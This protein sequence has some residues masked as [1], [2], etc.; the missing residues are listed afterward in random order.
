MV[1]NVNKDTTYIAYLLQQDGLRLGMGPPIP[2]RTKNSPNCQLIYN[3]G[4]CD[5]V[6]YNVP[7]TGSD[8]WNVTASYDDQAKTLFEPFDRAL[9]QFNCETTQYSLV[10]N[11]TD[12]YNDYKR[13][14]C[15]VSIPRCTS[16][17]PI[18]QVNHKPAPATRRINGGES[19]NPW[20]DE[21]FEVSEWTEMLPCIDL[22]YR[23][24]QSCP[25]FL[26]FFCPEGDL[27]WL[28]YGY[29]QTGTI[30]TNKSMVDYDINYPTCNRV[31]LNTSLLVVTEDVRAD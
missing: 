6:A 29:W 26:Q 12:C 23:V 24:V 30:E 11:C 1:S 22:C 13:W 7:A 21:K 10:R 16:P 4:F 15:A 27:A 17:S 9:S 28:Q 20:V 14:L 5:Q 8:I 25:P 18:D 3:L 31:G 19:R 2:V